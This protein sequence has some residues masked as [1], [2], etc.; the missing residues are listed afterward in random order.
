MERNRSLLNGQ[1]LRGL[2]RV[3]QNPKAGF[4]GIVV[5]WLSAGM[6]IP[7][8]RDSHSRGRP[9]HIKP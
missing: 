3:P 1:Q 2:D 8:R 6:R 7:K 5:R 4:N 9:A